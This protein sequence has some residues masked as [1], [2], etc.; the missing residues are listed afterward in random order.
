MEGWIVV[1]Q[2][3]AAEGENK[4]EEWMVGVC[5]KEGNKPRPAR[6]KKAPCDPARTKTKDEPK[7]VASSRSIYAPT[8]PSHPVDVPFRGELCA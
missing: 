1:E 5:M 7:K 2:K 6:T 4:E 3:S 8:A